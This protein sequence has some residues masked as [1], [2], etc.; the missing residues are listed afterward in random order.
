MQIDYLKFYEDKGAFKNSFLL[1]IETVDYGIWLVNMSLFKN[2]SG[3]TWFSYPS[4]PYTN[5]DNE[6]K[7][8]KLSYPNIDSQQ[9][10]E[11]D[12]TNFL[13]NTDSRMEKRFHKISQSADLPY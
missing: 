5:A 12:L 1:G 8:F 4:R 2:P 6:K 10:F 3:D 7:Y 11:E 9:L 13:I